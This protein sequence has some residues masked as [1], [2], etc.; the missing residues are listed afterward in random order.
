MTNNNP[1]NQSKKISPYSDK[2]KTDMYINQLPEASYIRQPVKDYFR[3]KQVVSYKRNV[4]DGWDMVSTYEN[5]K[6]RTYFVGYNPMEKSVRVFKKTD[7]RVKAKTTMTG[8]ISP[9]KGF[10]SVVNTGE[11]IKPMKKAR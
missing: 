10:S 7:G 8:D 11:D 3:D 6:E 5:G 4:G 9:K 2:D 1:Y